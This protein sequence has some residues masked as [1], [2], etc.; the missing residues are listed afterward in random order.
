VASDYLRPYRG[1][2]SINMQTWKGYA[3]YHSIQVSVNRRLSHGFAFGVAYTGSIR[4]SL[5]TF[6]PFL[7]PN[8]ATTCT[9][10]E[11]E[12][13]NKA[14]NYTY[15]TGNNGSRP[16]N[17]VINYNYQVPNPSKFWDHAIVRGVLDGW[18]LSGVT[19]IQSGVHAGFSYGFTGAPVND[20]TGGPGD[21]RVVLTC[22]P[23]LKPKDRTTDRQFR[24]EC[25]TFPGPTTIPGD[26]YYLGTSTN[27]EWVNLGYLNHDVTLFKTFALQGRR[28]LRFQAE[29]YNALNKTQYSGVG[30]GATFNFATGAQTNSTFGKITGVRGSSNR[31][32]QLGLRFAF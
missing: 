9:A 4:K 25:I 24:T 31:V 10:A 29:L 13:A 16:H 22:D 19:T 30:T 28:T 32:I 20:L 23:Y 26:I 27:D 6:N 3:N 17:L 7:C 2:G 11:N 12:A 18:Q 1:L 15:T 5:G 21:S 8:E 14:R